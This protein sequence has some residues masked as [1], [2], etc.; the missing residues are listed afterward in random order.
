MVKIDAERLGLRVLAGASDLRS[1][2]EFS[3]RSDAVRV[4][5]AARDGFPAKRQVLIEGCNVL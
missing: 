4:P 3:D 5:M 2:G 1:R